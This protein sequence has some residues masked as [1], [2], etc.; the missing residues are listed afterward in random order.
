MVLLGGHG[1]QGFPL[2]LPGLVV[3]ED[4]DEDEGG[5]GGAEDGDLVAEHDDAQP[6]RQGVFDS[7]GNTEGKMMI[8]INI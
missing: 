1:L 2:D 3:Q 7:A 4:P 8:C 5:A 6:N